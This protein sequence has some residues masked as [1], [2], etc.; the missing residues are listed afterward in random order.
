MGP[1]VY[2]CVR[3]FRVNAMPGCT[4]WFAFLLT[5]LLSGPFAEAQPN[6]SLS[7]SFP[8]E[9]LWPQDSRPM[10]DTSSEPD[11]MPVLVV[12]PGH[13][14]RDYG[15]V[16]LGG[17]QEKSVVFDIGMRLRKMALKDG[18]ID[19]KLTRRGDESQKL[20]DRANMANRAGGTGPA[21]L[22]VSIHVATSIDTAVAGYQVYY[23]GGGAGDFD[24]DGVFE[25]GGT[26]Q[27]TEIRRW[28]RQYKR[29]VARSEMFA[30]SVDAKMDEALLRRRGPMQHA[31][32]RLLRIVDMPACLI[33][34]GV[35]S[36][37]GEEARLQSEMSREKC[38]KAIY[39]GAL[40]FLGLGM[41]HPIEEANA[42]IDD[43]E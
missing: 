7:A 21:D 42:S 26:S 40:D 37:G 3:L 18:L 32:L 38:A 19:V 35:I 10:L 33:E 13:G 16:G 23:A 30:R 6:V 31:P 15:V 34:V 9:S 39:D 20:V 14:Y 12:D 25:I 22:L 27:P 24:I 1:D 36:N 4:V 43:A 29:H 8:E 11:R 41:E 2:K 17:V 5:I 28:N